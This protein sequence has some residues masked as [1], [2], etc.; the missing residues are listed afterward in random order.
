MIFAQY[1]RLLFKMGFDCWSDRCWV[2]Y[3]SWSWME[4][5]D[6][7]AVVREIRAGASGMIVPLLTR[8]YFWWNSAGT[9][10]LFFSLHGE[11]G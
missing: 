6:G 9:S 3:D 5:K 10:T 4:E 11:V 1:A 8:A 7:S 2:C